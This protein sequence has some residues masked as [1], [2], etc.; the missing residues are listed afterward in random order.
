MFEA[1]FYIVL[2]ILPLRFSEA[3]VIQAQFAVPDVWDGGFRGTITFPA[4][5]EF[6]YGWLL[7]ITF[8]IEVLN[9]EVHEGIVL[10]VHPLNKIFVAQHKAYNRH[11]YIDSTGRRS[12]GCQGAS[13]RPPA[14]EVLFIPM[15]SNEESVE[16]ALD[17]L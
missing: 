14:A 6:R 8:D 5:R 2:C 13:V 7:Y 16:N 17:A 9:F 3:E 1:A 15:L 10:G 4:D 12:L 11:L